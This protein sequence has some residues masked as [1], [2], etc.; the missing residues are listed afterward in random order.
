MYSPN[1]KIHGTYNECETTK[2]H[3]TNFYKPDYKDIEFHYQQYNKLRLIYPIKSRG[4][5]HHLLPNKNDKN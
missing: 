4:W 3:K 1:Q 2:T 5:K